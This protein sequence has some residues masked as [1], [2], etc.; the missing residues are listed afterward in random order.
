MQIWEEM[1]VGWYLLHELGMQSL[2]RFW[3]VISCNPFCGACINLLAAA[4]MASVMIVIMTASHCHWQSHGV[5]LINVPLLTSEQAV[6]LIVIIA[7]TFQ[8]LGY[9]ALFSKTTSH[10]KQQP[11]AATCFD[12]PILQA[13]RA[14]HQAGRDNS[15]HLQIFFL[16]HQCLN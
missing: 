1:G 9:P 12:L 15:R 5:Q 2:N 11:F 10:C 8:A 4:C 16:V 13:C 3:D 6:H 7:W 14:G